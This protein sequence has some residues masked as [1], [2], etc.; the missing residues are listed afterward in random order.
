MAAIHAFLRLSPELALRLA[1]DVDAAF[2]G[3]LHG[4]QA[5]LA[6]RLA[7]GRRDVLRAEELAFALLDEAWAQVQPAAAAALEVVARQWANLP[8]H[9]A[10]ARRDLDANGR[11]S[12]IAQEL[13]ARLAFDLAYDALGDVGALR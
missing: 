6:E 11:D 13:Y 3:D 12:W 2:D 1:A 4:L 5:K 9:V 10:E 8:A 7:R